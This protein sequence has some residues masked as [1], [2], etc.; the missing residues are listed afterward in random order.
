MTP[1]P[2]STG[3]H[4]S[5]T[6]VHDTMAYDLSLDFRTCEQRSCGSEGF[7]VYPLG[8]AF[9]PGEPWDAHIPL[10]PTQVY[11]AVE[12][13]L[14][15]WHDRVIHFD[16]DVDGT[17][18]KPFQRWWDLAGRP[19][20]LDVIGPPVAQAGEALFYQLFEKGG[21]DLSKLARRL[22]E[23]LTAGPVKM[24][25]L[26]DHLFA[27]W[28]LFH[29]PADAGTSPRSIKFWEGFWGARHVIDHETRAVGPRIVIDGA[30][31]VPTAVVIDDN[32]AVSAEGD[33]MQVHVGFFE[34]RKSLDV[35]V[36]RSKPELRAGLS[37][38]PFAQKIVYF[39]CHGQ[40]EDDGPPSIRLTDQEP[41][42]ASEID[43]WLRLQTKLAAHPIVFLNAC[44][45]GVIQTRLYETLAP[46]F[47]RRQAA[48]L[49]GAHTQV[50]TL[51]A[52]RYGQT[53][54]ERL[55]TP[56]TAPTRIGPLMTELVRQFI[57]VHNNPIGLVYTLYRA[58]D[59]YVSQTQ[60][61]SGR[62]DI[63][64]G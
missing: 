48:G 14:R 59:V 27:P 64:D 60:I 32:L 50:P 7:H 54:F 62:K 11:A 42:A 36:W 47:L 12:D 49:V 37:V 1:R 20:L 58:S 63:A 5:N 8:E 39:C 13:T 3:G 26:S 31:R 43:F 30:R 53:F 2:L 19:E 25:I 35:Q 24:R 45:G 6:P 34:G 51:F 41:I 10:T 61:E 23:V 21:E 38:D 55:L 16:L 33:T 17:T 52:T 46:Q 57:S 40:A 15:V 18:I 28:G 9:S 44:Q 22:R 29:L 4:V 56:S